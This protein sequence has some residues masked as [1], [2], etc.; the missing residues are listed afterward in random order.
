MAYLP[1]VPNVGPKPVSTAAAKP[2]SPAKQIRTENLGSVVGRTGKGLTSLGGGDLAAHSLNH[3]G[4][5]A[6]S[7]SIAM[8]RG[9]VGGMKRNV[10]AG[11]L[12]PGFAGVAGPSD[13]TST[14]SQDTE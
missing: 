2:A 7:K 11:G 4:K 5:P 12:G 6:K 10:R 8:I 1:G 9:G 14:Q 13:A 3:Y